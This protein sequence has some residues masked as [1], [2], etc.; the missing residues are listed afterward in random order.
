MPFRDDD[1]EDTVPCPHCGKAVYEDA[2]RCPYCETYLSEEDA[3]ARNP[4]WIILG[5]LGVLA[6]VALW[7]W[8][9]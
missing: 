7:I 5:A 2:E 3:P 4:W 1:G 8:M 9:G 6:A